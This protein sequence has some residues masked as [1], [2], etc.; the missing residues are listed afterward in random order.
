MSTRYTATAFLWS[1]LALG[2]LALIVSFALP[3]INMPQYAFSVGAIIGTLAVL[4]LL[5]FVYRSEV[6]HRFRTASGKAV[7]LTLTGSFGC[8]H[9]MREVASDVKRAIAENSDNT[10]RRDAVFLR[11]EMQAHY[12]LADTGVITREAC[13]NGTSLILTKF[14]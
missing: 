5:L 1:S 6:K 7:V 11:A 2:L 14:G 12:K 8:I 10:N 13:A 4:N 9:R 3:L